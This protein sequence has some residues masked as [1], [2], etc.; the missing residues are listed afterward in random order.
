MHTH[1]HTHTHELVDTFTTRSYVCLIRSG[2]MPGSLHNEGIDADTFASYGADFV[3]NDD[4]GV[5][6]ANAALDYGAMQRAI[7][8]VARPMLHNV[9]APDLTPASAREVC[10]LK[11]VGKDLKNDWQDMVRVLDT[12]MDARFLN[13]VLLSSISASSVTTAT[14]THC[15]HHDHHYHHHHHH[16][17]HHHYH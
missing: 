6:Y 14:V 15:R 13:E 7:A 2:K 11:R 3:K 10:Q 1:T 5:V 12:G 4:C 8:S 17:H 9:K 16:H